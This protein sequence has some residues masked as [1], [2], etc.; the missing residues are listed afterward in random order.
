[1][2]KYT[3][4][5]MLVRDKHSSL[6]GQFVSYGEIGVVNMVPGVILTTLHF[7]RNLRIGQLS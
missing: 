6:F 1:M 2:L 5:E 3:R 4:L 7:L